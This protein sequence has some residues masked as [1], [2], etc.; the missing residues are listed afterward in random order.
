LPYWQVDS[1]AIV[2]ESDHPVF[3]S[4]HRRIMITRPVSTAAESSTFENSSR[5]EVVACDLREFLRSHP[6]LLAYDVLTMVL[7]WSGVLQV[8]NE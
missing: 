5:L 6:Y 3:G 8:R 1:D 2:L 7:Q 4:I